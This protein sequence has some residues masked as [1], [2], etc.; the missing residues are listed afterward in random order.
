MDIINDNLRKHAADSI[1]PAADRSMGMLLL[2]AGKITAEDADRVTRHQALRGIRFGEAAVELKVVGHEDVRQVLAKQFQYPYLREGEAAFPEHL[3]AA[4]QPFSPAVESLRDLR[5][6]LVLRWFG[7]GRRALAVIGVGTDGRAASQLTSNLAVVFSQLGEQTLVMDC[8][9]R[10]PVQHDT[11]R[12]DG[13]QGLSD[14]LAQ[15]DSG[16]TVRRI[17]PFPN[18]SVLPSGT[19]PPNPLELLNRPA[20]RALCDD[21]SARYDVVLCEAPPTGAGTD[22]FAVAARVGGAVLVAHKDATRHADLRAAT[23]RLRQNGV[24]LVGSVLAEA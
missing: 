7:T 12:V 24:V 23:A 11:F 2:E 20:F 19:P 22:C 1:R 21:L 9:L 8:N 10:A 4:Y 18:L 17:E 14:V 16:E 3:V 6:Q 13:R 5:S 15:R